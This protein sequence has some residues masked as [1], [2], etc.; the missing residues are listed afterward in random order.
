M[1][2]IGCILALPMGCSG[3]S[4]DDI[5]GSCVDEG[6][7]SAPNRA[8]SERRGQIRIL[9]ER[10]TT[11]LMAG[12]ARLDIH[13]GRVTATF[14][15]VSAVTSTPAATVPLGEHCVGLTSRP[16]LGGQAELQSVGDLTLARAAGPVNVPALEPGRHA[17]VGSPLFS[18]GPLGL[19]AAGDTFPGFSIELNPP[20]ALE[21]LAPASDRS[22][23][24]DAAAPP[25][26]RWVPGSGD[27]VEIELTPVQPDGTVASGGQVS[28]RVADQGC[29]DLP[30][31][32]GVLL[33]ASGV[34]R[35]VASVRRI[36]QT[37]YAL[38]DGAE[39]EVALIASW[40]TDLDAEATP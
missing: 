27:A 19:E 25:R 17:W 12:S 2:A 15:D 13:R 26:F 31:S 40:R 32:A 28:C 36:R 24:F 10:D 14:G 30:A 29:F 3:A 35:F 1:R 16:V 18:E 7:P 20:E 21:L 11:D 33:A 4:D 38:S 9:D 34:R 39:L 37:V 22:E 5:G 8:E 23:V 6:A